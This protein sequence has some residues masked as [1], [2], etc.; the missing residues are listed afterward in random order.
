VK[1]VLENEFAPGLARETPN[2]ARSAFRPVRRHK[3]G[4][5]GS[6]IS[7]TSLRQASI[8]GRRNPV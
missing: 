3:Q 8:T 2:P 6:S 1:G 4:V 7:L 5:E